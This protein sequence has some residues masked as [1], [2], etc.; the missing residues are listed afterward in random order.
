MCNIIQIKAGSNCYILQQKGFA[1]LVD[2]GVTGSEKK[3]LRICKDY[4]V[5]LIV[6]THG[7]IDHIQNTAFLA[8]QLQVPIAMSKKD[9]DLI[10]DSSSHEMMANGWKGSIVKFFST[11]SVKS[12]T[13]KKFEPAIF[14]EEGDS[15][16]K[17][18]INAQV[19]EFPGHTAGSIGLKVGNHL[20][21]GDALMNIFSPEVSLL[22]ENKEELLKS[23]D[24]ITKM[25]DVKIYF[26]HGKPAKNRR[27]NHGSDNL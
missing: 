4:Q 24:K 22:Y 27:W 19:F 7:H 2:T 26:G 5:K 11:F 9:L 6:L 20:L 12:G 3:I 18:G 1:I 17:Y 25:G 10:H 21:V 15:L 16:L 8:K 14:L 23:A 13:I